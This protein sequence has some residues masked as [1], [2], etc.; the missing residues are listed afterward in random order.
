MK[1][2]RQIDPFDGGPYYGA[3]TDQLLPVQQV[4]VYTVD[5]GEPAPERRRQYLLAHENH[6]FRAVR[7]DAEMAEPGRLMVRAKVLQALGV[8][9]RAK[10]SAV[11][12]P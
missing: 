3:A 4:S 9:P 12:L 10:V 8:K 11:L 7:A 1:F 5:A 6:G 2:L